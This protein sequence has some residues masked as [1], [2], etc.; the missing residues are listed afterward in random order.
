MG[1]SGCGKSTLLNIIGLLDVP[2]SG[3][4]ELNGSLVSAKGDRALAA[5]RNKELGFVFQT[6]HLIA[7]LAVV[8]KHDAFAGDQPRD[9]GVLL[10]PPVE[11]R[12]PA[13]QHPRGDEPAGEA[14]VGADHG[15]LD[16]VGDDEK[17][18]EVERGHLAERT[19][20]AEA[21]PDEQGEVDDRRAESDVQQN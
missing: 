3:C 20:A 7:D 15:V 1:P 16:G 13:D 17:H 8:D 12:V 2:T 5:T 14:R 4:V 6:F 9:P 18:H 19:R 10:A 11:D 21:Q